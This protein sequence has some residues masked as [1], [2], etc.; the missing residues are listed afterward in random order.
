MPYIENE[1]RAALTEPRYNHPE[2]PGELNF[3]ITK[4]VNEYI[5][6]RGRAIQSTGLNYQL[7]AE[8]TGVLDNVKSE[9]YR[10]KAVPY[11]DVKIKEN[12]DVY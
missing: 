5:F 6:Y 10:R 9:F 7:I 1:R 12:G 3:L 8:I 2:A 11:E 4:L